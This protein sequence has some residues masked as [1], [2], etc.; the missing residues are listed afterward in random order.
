M[1]TDQPT[2]KILSPGSSE[3]DVDEEID[4]NEGEFDYCDV[5]GTFLYQLDLLTFSFGSNR[6]IKLNIY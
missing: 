3:I 4:E 2:V 1:I 5:S 6:R